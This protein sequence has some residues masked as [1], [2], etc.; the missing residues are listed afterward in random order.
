MDGETSTLEA[1]HSQRDSLLVKMEIAALSRAVQAQ[2]LASRNVFEGQSWG[3]IVDRRE[4]LY[5]SPD[6]GHTSHS[7]LRRE[8]RV[9]D[10]AFGRYRP[11]FEDEHDL[12]EQRGVG[13]YLAAC[14]GTSIGI[15]SSLT[16]YILGTGFTYRAQPR[17]KGSQPANGVIEIVQEIID[18]ISDNRWWLRERETVERCS[19]D[20]EAFIRVRRDGGQVVAKFVEP[21]VFAEPVGSQAWANDM[22]GEISLDWSFG[23]GTDYDD[24]ERVRG[25]HLIHDTRKQDCEFVP[26]SEIVHI[27]QNVPLA[28]KRGLSDYY[29]AFNEVDQSSRLSNNIAVGAM[30]QAAIAYIREHSQGV[31]QSQ[32]TA[33]QAIS[34]DTTRTGTFPGGS[35]KTQSLKRYIPGTVVDVPNGQQYKPGPMGDRNGAF[36]EVVQM[37]LRR[38][39]QRWNMPEYMVSGDAS[40]ANYSS[41]LVAE[42]PFIKSCE[43]KQILYGESF[44]DVMWRAVRLAFRWGA[45]DKVGA[46]WEQ[47]RATVAIV[48]DYPRISVRNRMEETSIRQTLVS[49]GIM[50]PRTWASQED[51]D[52]DE[53]Q[54]SGAKVALDA[55]MSSPAWAAGRVPDALTDS[56]SASAPAA[57]GPAADGKAKSVQDTALSGIQIEALLGLI[58]KLIGKQYPAETVKQLALASFPGIPAERVEA[59]I[60]SVSGFTPPT[61]VEPV[62]QQQPPQLQES[63]AM[64]RGYP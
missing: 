54:A 10:R 39:G 13:R 3:D 58:D 14:D 29:A 22:A 18:G 11:F 25:Y 21:D 17:H 33:F 38:L 62:P 28:V 50:S 5:D 49:A 30:I 7:L 64:W 20:G 52:Y 57:T 63:V 23:I 60:Q 61:P 24:S 59:I 42:S 45:F 36:I 44:I 48:I 53:E 12:A 19:T 41:T 43:A 55:G 4:Y 16:S 46:S 6:F 37:V 8:S 27:K 35:Q 47:V 1:L 2:E 40:N 51:L 56:A 31:S 32:I 34:R 26:A 15:L 9:D